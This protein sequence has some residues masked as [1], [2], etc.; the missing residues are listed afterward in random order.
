MP[1]K[2][3]QPPRENKNVTASPNLPVKT[4]GQHPSPLD[5]VVLVDALAVRVQHAQVAHSPSVA[6]LERRYAAEEFSMADPVVPDDVSFGR[7][8][9]D[10]YSP[11]SL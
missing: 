1:N 5:F 8:P 6:N 3:T 4:L 2:Y 7:N 10:R 11:D 9:H